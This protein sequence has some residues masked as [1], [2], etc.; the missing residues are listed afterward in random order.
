ML[1]F[2]MQKD[3]WEQ[4]GTNVGIQLQVQKTGMCFYHL[5]AFQVITCSNFAKHKNAFLKSDTIH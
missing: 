3:Y 4:T 2:L 1:T 5:F